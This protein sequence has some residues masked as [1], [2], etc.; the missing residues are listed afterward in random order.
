MIEEELRRVDRTR[1]E[2]ARERMGLV[3]ATH[4]F[5]DRRLRH[6]E[7]PGVNFALAA[8]SSVGCVTR[9]HMG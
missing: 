6:E 8:C 2:A 4:P 5:G 1:G 3:I 7:V 9:Q